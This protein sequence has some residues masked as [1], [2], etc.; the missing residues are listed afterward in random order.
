MVE[1]SSQR[2]LDAKRLDGRRAEKRLAQRPLRV[3]VDGQY[4][5][6]HLGKAARQMK[7]GRAL[8]AAPFLIDETDGRRHEHL[9]FAYFHRNVTSHVGQFVK[10]RSSIRLDDAAGGV[11]TSKRD[12]VYRSLLRTA[13]QPRAVSV[14]VTAEVLDCAKTSAAGATSEVLECTET[15]FG[16]GG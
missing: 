2:I 4:A 16:G 10:E 1:K 14:D 8:A 11:N 3:G 13:N 9:I 6:A 7:T 5:K 12:A 15:L